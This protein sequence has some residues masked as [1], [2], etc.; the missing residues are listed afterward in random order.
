MLKFQ[1]HGVLKFQHKEIRMYLFTFEPG[2]SMSYR[3]LFGRLPGRGLVPYYTVFGLAVGSAAP[4]AW[5]PFDTDRVS[6]ETFARHIAELM[7]SAYAYCVAWRLWLALTGQED[8]NNAAELCD[9]REDWRQQ[10]PSAAI[11]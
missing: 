7:E 10:L 6:E 11:G 9:W 2:D 8:D 3:V 1:R 5:Y 4:G